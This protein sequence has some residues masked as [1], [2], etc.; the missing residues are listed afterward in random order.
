VKEDTVLGDL[1]ADGLR[2]VRHDAIQWIHLAE[3]KAEHFLTI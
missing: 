2:E 1:Q 3:A